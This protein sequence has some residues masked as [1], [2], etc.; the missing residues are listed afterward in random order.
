MLGRALTLTLV[1]VLLAPVAMAQTT[2]LQSNIGVGCSSVCINGNCTSTC[3][4]GNSGA[5]KGSG[6]I[7]DKSY[8][9]RDFK[10][11]VSS[12][13]DTTVTRGET[14]DVTIT[15]DSNLIERIEVSQDGGTLSIKLKNGQYTEATI[16]A[17]ITMPEL[18]EL[19]QYGA[20][21]LTFSGFDQ[22]DLALNVMG[23]G[24]VQGTDN[25]VTNL[26]LQSQGASSLDMRSSELTNAEIHV[27]GSSEIKLNFPQGK[28]RI[29]GEIQGVSELLYCGD[30]V[31]LVN[32][33]GVAD[34]QRVNCS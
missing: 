6:D 4:E 2:I 28:G 10:A 15:A 29:S 26:I 20:A 3:D 21:S 34:I 13:I 9:L 12:D 33:F 8:G 19:T 23:A 7:V 16:R 30:P 22:T 24:V 25:L 5:I 27:D 18:R 11:V 17:R 32:V 31:N 1:S 14:F